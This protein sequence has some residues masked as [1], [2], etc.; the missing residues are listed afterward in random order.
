[1]RLRADLAF[2]PLDDEVVVF[3]EETQ[4]L[5]GLNASAAH[6]AR[7]V[8]AG[9]PLSAIAR[10]LTEKGMTSPE[11]AASWVAATLDALRS[12]GMAA[13]GPPADPSVSPD[14]LSKQQTQARR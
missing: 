7:E 10:D 14:V 13:D 2:L 3:S 9:T 11:E 4:S 8:K 6:V 1:M 5:V 12:H